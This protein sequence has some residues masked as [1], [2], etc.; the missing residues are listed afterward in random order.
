MAKL[1]GLVVVVVVII[2]IISGQGAPG[3]TCEGLQQV[4]GH[5]TECVYRAVVK[6]SG[7]VV[8]GDE[9]I[10]TLIGLVVVVAALGL[11]GCTRKAN[12]TLSERYYQVN[13]R[14]GSGNVSGKAFRNSRNW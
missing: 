9:G 10:M 14:G 13:R 6:G 2:V 1:I 7:V 12:P 3:G 4:I 5:A 11:L 8:D